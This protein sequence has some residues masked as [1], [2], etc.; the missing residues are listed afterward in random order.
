M[1]GRRFRPARPIPNRPA[2]FSTKGPR[3]KPG[4]GGGS[5]T[6]RSSGS[7][8]GPL[9][10]WE[11]AAQSHP[12]S[13]TGHGGLGPPVTQ[14][15]IQLWNLT[16]H[17]ICKTDD[18]RRSPTPRFDTKTTVPWGR[19]EASLY[20][21]RDRSHAVAAHNPVTPDLAPM[22]GRSPKPL[23]GREHSAPHSESIVSL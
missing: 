1:H 11:E 3:T 16:S 14:T 2:S 21:C 19:S 20:R 23:N 22:L 13:P 6:A 10:G 15:A 17:L 12:L 4:A 9:A 5:I 18:F 8:I 7:S